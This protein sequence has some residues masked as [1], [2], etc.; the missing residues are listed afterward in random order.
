MMKLVN[1]IKK[2]EAVESFI[3]RPRL[4]LGAM[5]FIAGTTLLLTEALKVIYR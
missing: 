3:A 5:I 2:S 1:E 4:A